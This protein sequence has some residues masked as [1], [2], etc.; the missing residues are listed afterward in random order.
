MDPQPLI[1]LAK[2]GVAYLCIL[3]GVIL[4]AIFTY[5]W[6]HRNDPHQR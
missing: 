2:F 4:Y 6:E 3:V 1:T 5:N